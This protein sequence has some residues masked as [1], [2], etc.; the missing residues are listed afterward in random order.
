MDG[1]GGQ[2]NRKNK[3]HFSRRPLGYRR[4]SVDAHLAT[5]DTHIASLQAALDEALSDEQQELVLRATRR[6]VEDVLGSAEAD[7]TEIRAQANA[8]A[9]A[10]LADAYEL[11]RARDHVIDLRPDP[12][13]A[14]PF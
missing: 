2:M 12:D 10:I 6:S 9:A 8:D 1:E 11:G 14:T 3:P 4:R 7:A 5:V 13:T